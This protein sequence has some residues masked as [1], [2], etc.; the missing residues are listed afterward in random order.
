LRTYPDSPLMA[1]VYTTLAIGANC[2]NHAAVEPLMKQAIRL[3]NALL[4]A[5]LSK[6]MDILLFA[7]SLNRTA[8][9]YGTLGDL[10]NTRY[11]NLQA[12][13]I[14][15]TLLNSGL[16]EILNNPVY[17]SIVWVRVTYNLDLATLQNGYEWAKSCGKLNAMAYTLFLLIV[18]LC[19]PEMKNSNAKTRTSIQEKQKNFTKSRTAEELI[20]Y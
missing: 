10:S 13:T 4:Q 14:L 15:Y 1:E 11:F 19:N 18:T 8:Q 6:E 9:Y 12:Y 2:T 16:V 7:D 17:E 3:Q 20:Q 5:K